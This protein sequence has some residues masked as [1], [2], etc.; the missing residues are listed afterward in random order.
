MKLTVPKS[1]RFHSRPR[2]ES[3]PRL[4]STTRELL[5]VQAEREAWAKLREE[6]RRAMENAR[7]LETMGASDGKGK[8]VSHEGEKGEAVEMSTSGATSVGAS[9]SATPAPAAS[10]LARVPRVPRSVSAAPRAVVAPPPL[11][12]TDSESAKASAAAASSS[13]MTTAAAPRVLKPTE[14][15]P[16]KLHVDERSRARTGADATTALLSTEE[17]E[18]LAMRAQQFHAR[19]FDPRIKFSTGEVG[20]AR[21]PKKPLTE[22]KTPDLATYK[23][24][25]SAAS[26]DA[27]K[28]EKSAVGSEMVAVAAATT[29]AAPVGSTTT[30]A[31]GASAETSEAAREVVGFH[32]RP[33]PRFDAPPAVPARSASVLTT[34][35]SPILHTKARAAVR[36]PVVGVEA[37]TATAATTSSAST[38]HPLGPT[39]PAPFALETE[40]RHARHAMEEE[41]RRR[42]EE[43]ALQAHREFHARPAPTH[44]LHGDGFRPKHSEKP[45]TTHVTVVLHSDA[46]AEERARFDHELERRLAEQAAEKKREEEERMRRE[47]EEVERLRRTELVFKARPVPSATLRMGGGVGV[48]GVGGGGMMKHAVKVTVPKSP[49]LHTAA[50][51]M[52]TE[53]TGI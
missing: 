33:M 45:V 13:T 29:T 17:R 15:K 52:A 26:M 39:I 1:P 20:V 37:A 38:D 44:V 27:S 49:E 32:A 31:G 53:R 48:V 5:R 47:Q 51:A 24:S 11:P 43:A 23:R 12:S 35:M 2:K 42:Q 36:P 28:V 4:S 50:R 46:R 9:T 40:A 25:A 21:A 8:T 41:A 3:E 19:P 16:F 7:L 6:N 14:P 18:L 22:P 10:T 34:P 30:I